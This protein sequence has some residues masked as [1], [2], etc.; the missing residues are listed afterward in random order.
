MV[1]DQGSPR[2][3]LDLC[4]EDTDRVERSP[5]RWIV[6]MIDGSPPSLGFNGP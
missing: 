6:R 3:T 5:G 2:V 1:D 4:A